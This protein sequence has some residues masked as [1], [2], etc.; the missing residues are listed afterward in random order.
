MQ[1][2]QIKGDIEKG[3]LIIGINTTE[4]GC[5]DVKAIM[6]YYI[7]EKNRYLI[8]VYLQIA[9]NEEIHN[10]F[11]NIIKCQYSK[12]ENWFKQYLKDNISNGNLRQ[13]CKIYYERLNNGM[14]TMHY[15]VEQAILINTVGNQY[16]TQINWSDLNKVF[17]DCMNNKVKNISLSTSIVMKNVDFEG[18]IEA[19]FIGSTVGVITLI[20]KLGLLVSTYDK[21]E[22]TYD[23]LFTSISIIMSESDKQLVVNVHIKH[24]NR[25]QERILEDFIISK[26]N[27]ITFTNRENEVHTPMKD[28]SLKDCI[29]LDNKLSLSSGRTITQFTDLYWQ[30]LGMNKQISLF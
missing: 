28:L 25:L 16:N 22:V 12:L 9:D 5:N 13:E 14:K 3:T 18:E 27:E 8:Y 1:I 21:C 23:K 30:W 20:K 7:Q 11:D 10:I 4:S 2:R 19:S 26:A 6:D 24:N 29:K 17:N 15:S